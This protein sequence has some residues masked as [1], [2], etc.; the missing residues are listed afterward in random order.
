MPLRYASLTSRN[1][2]R[3]DLAIAAGIN[4]VLKALVE[5]KWSDFPN[6]MAWQVEPLKNILLDTVRAA[7]NAVISDRSYLETFGIFGGDSVSA[8][9]LWSHLAGQIDVEKELACNILRHCK[10][11]IAC[12]SYSQVH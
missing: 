3:A 9:E 8:A 11:R 4:A 7:E 12:Q 6:Q 10:E 2:P 1:V 5:E